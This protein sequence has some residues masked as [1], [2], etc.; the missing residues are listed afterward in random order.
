MLLSSPGAQ[1]VAMY[2]GCRAVRSVAMINK[3]SNCCYCQ[4]LTQRY[5]GTRIIP[6]ILE[7]LVDTNW[8]LRLS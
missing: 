5:H 6:G 2:V 8:Q 3:V 1:N 4:I 7:P